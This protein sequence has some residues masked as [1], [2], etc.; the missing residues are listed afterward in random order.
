MSL[1]KNFGFIRP[2]DFTWW[3]W[4]VTAVLLLLGLVWSP[5]LLMV[6]LAVS[7]AQMIL[8]ILKEK[9]IRSFAAQLRIAYVLFLLVGL[10]PPL[11][12]ILWIPTIGTFALVFLGYCLLARMLSLLP[13]NRTEP[14][15]AKLL[16]RTFL[17]PPTLDTT[18]IAPSAASC[19]GAVCTL[20]VQLGRGRTSVR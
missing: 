3:I 6:A 8:F 16:A 1:V 4:L 2:A 5:P 15:T 11:R 14:L 10:I 18:V 12:P 9:S 7:I 13:W 19:P 17:T 20:Q